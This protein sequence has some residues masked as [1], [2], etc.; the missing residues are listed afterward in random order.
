LPAGETSPLKQKITG[1][2]SQ[3]GF[4]AGLGQYSLEKEVVDILQDIREKKEEYLRA[5]HM[6]DGDGTRLFYPTKHIDICVTR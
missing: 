3:Y 1:N 2:P 5:G 6:I 4:W